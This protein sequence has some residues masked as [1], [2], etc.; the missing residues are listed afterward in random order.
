MPIQ[1]SGAAR[2][3]STAGTATRSIQLPRFQ[4]SQAPASTPKI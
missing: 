3:A 1:N 2:V 4:A